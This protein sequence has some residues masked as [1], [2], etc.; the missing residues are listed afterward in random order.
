MQQARHIGKLVISLDAEPHDSLA[1]VASGAGMIRTDATY[2]VTGGLSGVGLATAEWLVAQGARSL[3][4]LGR[5]GDTTEEAQAGLA[6]MRAAGASPRAFAVDV[7]DAA[8]L[9]AVLQQV[10]ASMPPLRGVIHSAA[11]IEDAPLIKVDRAL[12]HNVMSAKMLGAWTLHRGDA[13]GRA[14]S[15]R[16]VFLLGCG[17][18]QSRSGGLC[19]RQQLPQCAGRAAAGRGAAG[20]R[21]R[22]GRDQGCRLPHPQR[23]GREHAGA[24]RRHGGDAHPR[25]PGRARSPDGGRG[26]C[27]LGCAVQPD[28]PRPEPARRP[29]PALLQPDPGRHGDDGAECRLDGRC[30]AGDGLGG[31]ARRD[32][33]LRHRQCRAAS[34]ARRLRRWSR[35]ARSRSWGWTR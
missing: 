7:S 32:P 24:A 11:L 34:S 16:D 27:R 17:R 12:M 18:R 2:L 25:H 35:I 33:R 26:G 31:A 10:R 9:E 3:A 22:L 4:L 14:R 19:R 15:L 5:R 21:C 30:A 29:H 6:R 1:V 20:A 28:A 8:A 23:A 13:A